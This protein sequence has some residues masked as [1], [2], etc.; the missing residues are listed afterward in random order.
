MDISKLKAGDEIYYSGKSNRY[1]G[2]YTVV[3]IENRYFDPYNV[4][5]EDRGKLLAVRFIRVGLNACL[6]VDKLDPKEWDLIE[7]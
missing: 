1:K 6:E 7:R 4:P 2:E 3:P 5:S